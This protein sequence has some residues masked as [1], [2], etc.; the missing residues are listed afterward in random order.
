MQHSQPLAGLDVLH[1]DSTAIKRHRSAT[2]A[3]DGAEEAIGRSRSR[4]ATKVHHA[5][6]SLGLVRRLLT[7]PGQHADCRHTEALTQDFKH[8]TVVGDKGY[9]SDKLRDHWRA[10]QVG[11]CVPPK[12]NRLVQHAYDTA[13]YHTRHMGENS[14]NRLKDYRRLSL[15]L[16]KTDTSYRAFV[17]FTAAQMNLRLKSKLC[18]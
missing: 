5:V 13:L 8:V 15:R 16:H 7:S 18:S 10:R 1:M 14:F 2:G 9:D 4:L 11:V 6:D 12:R 17:P 3:R